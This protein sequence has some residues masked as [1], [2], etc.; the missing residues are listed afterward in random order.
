MKKTCIIIAGP[1]AIGKTALSIGLA[2]QFSTQIISADSRQCFKELN[3]G[4]AKPSLSQLQ[5]V[6]HYFINS[7]S[8]SETVSAIAFENYALQSIQKIF[9]KADVA[10]M[11]G[12]TGLYINAFCE[13]MDPIPAV[14]AAIRNNI[15]ENYKE[16]GMEWL[17]EE[18]LNTDQV[19]AE[20]GEMQNPQRMMRAL[21]VKISTGNSI[22]SYQ[23]ANKKNR[24]FDII[25]IG[26]ELPR[27]ILYHQINLRVDHM[28]QEGL[29]EEVEA[30]TQY[31]SL[32]ALQ[33]VGYKELFDYFNGITT[34]SAAV[35][36][37]KQNTRRYAKRQL[38]WFKKDESY[39]W[40]APDLKSVSEFVNSSI[41]K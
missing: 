23:R 41:K 22:L 30:L 16:K 7:H 26:L 14:S 8:I 12:G 1:T 24:D 4:V 29:K 9:E 40:F 31:A 37:I 18:L 10:L 36:L 38:T 3:I 6:S 27:E 5:Q 28:I 13:G 34:Y 20:K 33:T 25:K 11:V 39:H 21:E 17:R 15:I 32:N 2:Q 35:E 19:Y